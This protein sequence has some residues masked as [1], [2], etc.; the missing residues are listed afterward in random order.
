MKSKLIVFSIL[1]LAVSNL[2][3]RWP[4]NSGV[5]TSTYGESR[6]DHFHDGIDMISPDDNVHPIEQGTLLFT[7][8]K[9]LFPL[10]NYWG[11]GNFKILVHNN[12]SLS[13]YMHL[14]DIDN[15]KESYSESDTLGQVGDTGHSYGKH[16]HF[17]VLNP[18]NR[19]SINP[20][21][22]LPAYA[23]VK[24]PEIKNFYIRIENRY[25]MIKDNSDIR[26][27]KH[28][29]LLVEIKDTIK[30]NENLGLYNIKAV[31]NGK[32]VL[33]YNFYKI[34]YSANGLAVNSRTFNDIY[35]EKGYYKINGLTYNDGIN[36]ISVVVSDYNGNSSEKTF[37]MNVNLDM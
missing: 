37:S 25:I 23:D 18:G 32:E 1:V 11:G 35:D 19:E 12:G 28:Y 20:F 22:L 36:T 21:G 34:D 8:N 5:I 2:S 10:E 17:S 6:G 4:V 3:Y 27:T 13:V 33:N 24:A 29:P 30:G 26:L 15:L 7:W 9:S 16:I 14:Q 31:F